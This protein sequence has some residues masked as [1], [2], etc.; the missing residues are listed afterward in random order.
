DP[1]PPVAAGCDPP[2]PGPQPAAAH[3]P[4]E[5]SGQPAPQPGRAL[6]AGPA[7][8][9]LDLAPGLASR[10]DSGRAGGPGLPAV[11][12]AGA[13]GARTVPA[14]ARCGLSGRRVGGDGDRRGPGLP[15]G[16]AA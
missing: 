8:L 1:V 9:R 6:A 16:H 5:N 10:M 4:L 2:R 12:A 11:P 13:P 15:P 7:L 14:A 3:Q